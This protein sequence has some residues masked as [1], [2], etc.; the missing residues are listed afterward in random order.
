VLLALLVGAIASSIQDGAGA[1]Q[2]TA[3]MLILVL[4]YPPAVMARFAQFMA[5]RLLASVVGF[6]HLSHP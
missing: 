2:R 1:R 4:L 6:H 3:A 5:R